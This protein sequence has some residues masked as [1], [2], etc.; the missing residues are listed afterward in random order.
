MNTFPLHDLDSAGP[1]QANPHLEAV[2]MD[3]IDLLASD[4]MKKAFP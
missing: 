1:E 3:L 4:P 2:V